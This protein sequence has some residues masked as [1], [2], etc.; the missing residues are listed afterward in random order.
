MNSELEATM[1]MAER[2]DDAYFALDRLGMTLMKS[3]KK[4]GTEEPAYRVMY[5]SRLTIEEVE[6]IIDSQNRSRRPLVRRAA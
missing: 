5:K 2:E 4:P 3:G 1:A 6:A